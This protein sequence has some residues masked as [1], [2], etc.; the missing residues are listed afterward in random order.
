MRCPGMAA[1]LTG[2][3]RGRGPVGRAIA[4]RS[5]GR[6]LVL[7]V[8][9][10]SGVVVSAGPAEG[11]SLR[12]HAIAENV[13]YLEFPSAA[14]PPP[15]EAAERWRQARALE[16]ATELRDPAAA[17]V[18]FL[19]HY[20]AEP[21][22]PDRAEWVVIAAVGPA[23]P[24]EIAVVRLA[25]TPPYPLVGLHR[26]RFGPQPGFSPDAA[27]ALLEGAPLGPHAR[28][29]RGPGEIAAVGEFYVYHFP[30][31]DFGGLQVLSRAA[32]ALVFSASTVAL[33]VG[34]LLV[35]TP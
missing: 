6:A 13:W 26:M 18:V 21:P 9:L 8:A 33:G 2:P 17:Q 31:T 20:S 34:R 4:G 1:P 11:A 28:P 35:P 23:D 22:D 10:V 19:H 16:A 3:R 14:L 32:G 25:A 5:C 30:P 24:V 27:V 7:A 29:P 15:A 12:A